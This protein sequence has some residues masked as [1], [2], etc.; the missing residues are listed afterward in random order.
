MGQGDLARDFDTSESMKNAGILDVFPIFHTAQLGQKIRQSPQFPLCGVAFMMKLPDSCG[1]PAVFCWIA[2]HIRK[3]PENN[4]HP[5]G[6]DKFFSKKTYNENIHPFFDKFRLRGLVRNDML[7]KPKRRFRRIHRKRDEYVVPPGRKENLYEKNDENM[8]D[9][10]GSGAGAVH[11]AG[12]RRRAHKADR[13]DFCL[14][15]ERRAV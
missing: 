3:P 1:N 8:V 10:A 5:T 14:P 11:T 7:H 2:R 6:F 13:A 12:L 15:V 9:F 4:C